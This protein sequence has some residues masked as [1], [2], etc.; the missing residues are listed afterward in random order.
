MPKFKIKRDD[1]GPPGQ[2]GNYGLQLNGISVKFDVTWPGMSTNFRLVRREHT[3]AG[4]PVTMS[5][6]RVIRE[7]GKRTATKEQNTLRFTVSQ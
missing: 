7:P 6:S 1:C 4:T 5:G 2:H 3:V